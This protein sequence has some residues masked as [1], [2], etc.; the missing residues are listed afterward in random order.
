MTMS[1]RDRIF[2]HIKESGKS[3]T[4][5]AQEIGVSA[6][7]L[8][9][10]L[11]GKYPNPEAVESKAEEFFSLREKAA[12]I[13]KAPDYVPTSIS[14][15]VYD[16]ISY[17]HI[18]RCIVSIVGDAGIGK[19]KGA[20]KYAAD[21]SEVIFIT[22]SKACKSL[23]DMYRMIARKLRLNENRN[24]FDMQVDIRAKL[25]GSN[26][27]LV[28]D[29]AQHLSLT[30]IDGIRY[31]NDEDGETGLPPIGIVLIGNHELRTKMLG[32]NEASLAQLFNR[33]QMQRLLYTN[34]LLVDDI[35][36]L[37]PVYVEK[38]MDNE[39]KFLHGIAQ[40][41][42]GVR[43]AVKIFMNASNASDISLSGLTTMAK[44]MGIGVAC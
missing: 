20:Q 7:M 41:R 36:K 14:Q 6:P 34:N 1:I 5:V 40:S 9:Q 30:A 33:I 32:R 12:A 19:T 13:A 22:A 26:K 8:N 16:M 15:Q 37:F 17:G 21:Y 28:I 35:K 18:N 42:W 24:L 44:Y 31:F 38:S 23:K 3:Q 11:S 39:I 10:Y 2:Q 25:D 4:K 29:E 43:G 27:V